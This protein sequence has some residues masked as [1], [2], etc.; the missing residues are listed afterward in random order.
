LPTVSTKI[1]S[2][3]STFDGEAPMTGK[4]DHDHTGDLLSS[5]GRLRLI[6]FDCDGTLV[7]SQHNIISAV[8][9]VFHS[10]DL[11]PPPIDLIRRQIGL[12][13]NAAIAGML[14]GK[15]P[16]LHRRVSEAFRQLRPQ[17]Q[18][19]ARPLDPLYPGI[20]HLIDR[21]SHPELF[22]GIATGKGRAGLDDL[23][24]RH[25]LS[26]HFHT[27]QTGDRCRGKPDP[28]MLQRAIAETGLT[29]AQTV[30]IGDT[31]FDMQMAVSA[32]CLAVGVAWGYH[33]PE[34]LRAGGAAA[35]IAHP[36]DFLPTLR[37]LVSQ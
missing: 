36:D 24:H 21:L 35:V 17:L 11:A 10:I 2:P 33:A 1:L 32:G 4:Q 3:I 22:L 9:K 14:P 7:D 26:G 20:H 12:A 6:V 27:V 37:Y 31:A 18:A 30:M 28:D 16:A 19:E 5:L 23:L 34:D 8:E 29:P 25:G 13:P 15:G